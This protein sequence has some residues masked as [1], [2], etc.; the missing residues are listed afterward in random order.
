M[1][2]IKLHTGQEGISQFNKKL[3][4]LIL[5]SHIEDNKFNTSQKE[6]LKRLLNSE[7]EEDKIILK[8]ILNVK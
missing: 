7:L 4:N 5:N 1:R 3:Q 2:S 8:E 6:N